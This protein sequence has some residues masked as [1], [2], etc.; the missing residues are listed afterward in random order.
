MARKQEN[1]P[2]YG[3]QRPPLGLVALGVIAALGMI[4]AGALWTFQ[5][6][7]SPKNSTLQTFGP[8]LA[9][10]GVALGWVSVRSVVRPRD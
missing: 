10:L 9:G 1:V 7:V 5:W 4:V 2:R 3:R 6:G 8:I